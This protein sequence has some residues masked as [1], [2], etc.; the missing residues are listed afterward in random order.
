MDPTP[1][2]QA[3]QSVRDYYDT[4]GVFLKRFG[5]GKNPGLVVIDMAYGWTDPAYATGSSRL[6]GRL[7]ES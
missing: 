5:F 7:K 3:I 2:E 6:D 1:V 4:H